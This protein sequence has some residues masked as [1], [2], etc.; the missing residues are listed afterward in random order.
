M[1]VSLYFSF[2]Q[3]DMANPARWIGLGNFIEM[4]GD[5]RFQK[6]LSVTFRYVVYGVPFH[7]AFALFLAVVLKKNRRGI[8]LYRAIYYL[9]SLFGAS[10]AVALL[11]RQI[12]N[13]EGVVNRA[14]ALFGIAGKNWIATPGTVL[15][16]L[17]LLHVWQ[18]GSSMVVF[19]GG[20]K[21]ISP[22]YY[23]AAEID[24]AGKIGSFFHITLPLLTPMVF[25]NIVMTVIH[26]F[27]AFTASYIVSNGT[28]S[29]MDS[30]LFYTLYLYIR[31]FRQFSMGY[32]SA[33]AWV[34]LII[35]AIITRLLFCIADKW[36]FY[37]E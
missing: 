20:L 12:F 33:M 21:Q 4:I 7:L 2:T 15:Y 35:I 5:R 37:D 9:P 36:V 19:L 17:I 10:V 31:A 8:R 22:D 6:S 1:F 32:A 29:P 14:L 13:M 11:W 34:L 25:F 18:F 28:G 24:G 23:E 30:T 16:T 27:Q 26:A 3:Y